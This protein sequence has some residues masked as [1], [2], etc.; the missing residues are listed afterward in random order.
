MDEVIF[1]II[2]LVKM[3]TE[4]TRDSMMN[5][6]DR[7]DIILLDRTGFGHGLKEVGT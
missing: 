5:I 4:G 6:W 3:T 2:E 7:Y 1:M